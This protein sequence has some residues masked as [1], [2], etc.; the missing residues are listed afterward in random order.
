MTDFLFSI[1]TCAGI[2][3]RAAFWVTAGKASTVLCDVLMFSFVHIGTMIC[4]NGGTTFFISSQFTHLELLI[5][6]RG[7]QLQ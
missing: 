1:F 2:M 3:S 7:F 6:F 5:S 4:W